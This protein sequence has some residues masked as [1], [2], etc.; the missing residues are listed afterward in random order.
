MKQDREL[1][2]LE[3]KNLYFA[4]FPT[5]YKINEKLAS[6]VLRVF[7]NRRFHVTIVI[8]FAIVATDVRPRG[9]C[10]LLEQIKKT[11]L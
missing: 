4:I 2:E 5:N 11:F 9:S 6:V 8:P 1:L 7:R 10:V 3:D